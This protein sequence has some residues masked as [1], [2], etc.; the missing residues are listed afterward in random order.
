AV[1]T[2]FGDEDFDSAGRWIGAD[3]SLGGT[4]RTIVSAYV[5][6]GEADTA[7][8]DEK[9][10]FLDAMEQR[11]PRLAAV[12]PLALITSDLN[13]GHREADIK[14]W[15]GNRNKAGFLPRE[16]AYFDRFFGARGEQIAGVDG[17]TGAGHGWVD[18]GRRFHPDVAGPYTW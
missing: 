11:M 8:Q 4:A 14:N 17:S 12:E 10:R 5:H 3:L 16:R 1:R 7:K 2:A 18:V 9:W 13:V 15:R 6:T